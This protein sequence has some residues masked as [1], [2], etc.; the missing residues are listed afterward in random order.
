[1]LND[2]FQELETEDLYTII[3]SIKMELCSDML[4]SNERRSFLDRKLSRY[5]EEIADRI[6]MGEE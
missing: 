6:L 3:R 5:K 2:F 4:I 1:M